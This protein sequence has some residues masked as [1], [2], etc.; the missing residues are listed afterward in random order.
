MPPSAAV[1]TEMDDMGEGLRARLPFVA[2]A[3]LAGLYVA[4]VGPFWNISPDSVT[5][6]RVGQDLAQGRGLGRAGAL[7]VLTS[8]AYAPVL[9]FAPEG[10]GALNALATAL[11]LLSLV[12]AYRLIRAKSGTTHAILVV[13]LTLAYTRFFR[14]STQLLSEP[15]YLLLTMIVLLFADRDRET[16][17]RAGQVIAGCALILAALTRI[18]GLTLILAVLANEA[19]A[20]RSRRPSRPVLL[21]LT[22]GALGA[23]VAWEVWSASQGNT[24]FFLRELLQRPWGESS[25][26]LTIGDVLRTTLENRAWLPAP[27][28]VL[29]NAWIAREGLLDLIVYALGTVVFLGGL[30]LAIR[31]RV[32]ITNL[33]AAIYTAVILYHIVMTGGTYRFMIP[34]APL[35]FYYALI[36]ATA[37]ADRL[38]PALRPWARVLG[39]AYVIWFVVTGLTYMVPR[40]GW[41]HRTP[42]PDSPSKRRSNV[43]VQRLGMRIGELS[44]PDERFAAAQRDMVQVFADRRGVDLYQ[45]GGDASALLPWLR[46]KRIR[47]LLLDMTLDTSA[48]LAPAVEA[49]PDVYEPIELLPGARLYRVLPAGG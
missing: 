29:A 10:Y 38:R 48:D 25:S 13:G 5:Y 42:F 3:L 6:V 32:T 17:S 21:T 43:D 34:I 12:V 1:R 30:L 49:S 14:E 19:W 27:G 37:A 41:E 7:P 2:L 9:Y 35:V 11:L 24:T 31:R 28:A 16:D 40:V 22:L 8:F 36:A 18:V 15:L 4:A 33:Y 47:Y 44:E 26:V 39:A 20:R 46:Q 45:L 23:M